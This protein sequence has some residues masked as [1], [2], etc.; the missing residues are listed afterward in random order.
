MSEDATLAAKLTA[1]MDGA[2]LSERSGVP[3]A[4]RRRRSLAADA[5]RRGAETESERGRPVEPVSAGKRVRR[6]TDE[7]GVR[8]A[9]RDHGPLARVC[10]GSVQLLGARYRQHGSARPLRH[11]GTAAPLAR[12]AARGH[13][14]LLLRDD[15]A[16]RRLVRRD[17]HRARGSSATATSTSSTVASGTSPAPA[18]RAARSPSSWGRPTRQRRATSSSR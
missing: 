10:A 8:A 18:I 16:R 12:A 6:R 13:D 3:R 7:H 5:D 1:F 14:P 9:L 11:R 2:H 4:D 17:E 15:R